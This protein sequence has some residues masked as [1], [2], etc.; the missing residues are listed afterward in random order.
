MGRNNDSTFEHYGS[1]KKKERMGNKDFKIW[2]VQLEKVKFYLISNVCM[3][4]SALHI[5][6]ASK[7]Y[8]DCIKTEIE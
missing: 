6:S 3:S 8:K 4:N 7:R 2:Q 1:W 5:Y